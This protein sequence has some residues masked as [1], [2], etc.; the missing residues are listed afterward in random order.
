MMAGAILDRIQ[1]QTQ[2]VP[3]TGVEGMRLQG[4]IKASL[5]GSV[6]VASMAGMSNTSLGQCPS[7]GNTGN[8]APR[9]TTY[10]PAVQYA[11]NAAYA[12]AVSSNAVAP[13]AVGYGAG[14]PGL[15]GGVAGH[16]MSTTAA[17]AAVNSGNT[18]QY[19]NVLGKGTQPLFENYFTQGNANQA[20]A[21]MYMSP[22]GVPGHVG[23]TYYTYQ[24]LYPHHYLY[25]HHDRYHSYY[26]GGRGLNRTKASY[27]VPPVSGTLH[28]VH[29]AIQ[30]PHQ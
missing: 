7:C 2:N 24:P 8:A 5:A 6:A 1:Q 26:D 13:G 12:P 22:I 11:P 19:G 4:L 23:H 14:R 21:G 28:W 25:Q 30:L 27:S 18:E 3:V 15:V 16:F 17:A 20:T 10:A 29:K 9:P